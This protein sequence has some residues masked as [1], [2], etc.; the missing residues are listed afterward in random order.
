MA[1]V[2]MIGMLCAFAYGVIRKET[3]KSNY[4]EE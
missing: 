1:S 3:R 2:I 4:L